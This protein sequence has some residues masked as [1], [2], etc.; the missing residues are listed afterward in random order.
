MNKF[1]SPQEDK[2]PADFEKE[3]VEF[4]S[5][6]A[7]ARSFEDLYAA[8]EKAGVIEGSQRTYTAAEI[9]SDIEL[10]VNSI[11]AHRSEELVKTKDIPLVKSITRA[12]GI[13]DKVIELIDEER[14]TKTSAE[15]RKERGVLDYESMTLAQLQKDPVA[16]KVLQQKALEYLKTQDKEW[17]EKNYNGTLDDEGYLMEKDGRA[18]TTPMQNIGGEGLILVM[19]ETKRELLKDPRFIQPREGI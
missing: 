6:I 11:R 5:A 1:E 18:L 3:A 13:R 17:F 2:Q 4:E 10:A 19:Q 9:R 12:H 16:A 7:D 15:E 14:D 8:L